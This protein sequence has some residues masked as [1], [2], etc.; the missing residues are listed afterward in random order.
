METVCYD[1][2]DMIA[3]PTDWPAFTSELVSFRLL[4]VGFSEFSIARIPRTRNLRADFL[5]KEARSSGVLF[6]HIDET[7]PDRASFRNVSRPLPLDLRR[8]TSTKKKLQ[9][10]KKF[11]YTFYFQNM[12]TLAKIKLKRVLFIFKT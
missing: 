4:Q 1:L 10:R 6:S 11:L 5:A 2:V 7:Q 3:N 12:T 9:M 8:W